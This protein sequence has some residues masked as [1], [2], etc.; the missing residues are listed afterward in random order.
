LTHLR[1][2]EGDR[3]NE[4]D[5]LDETHDVLLGEPR[6]VS[7]DGEV[8]DGIEKGAMKLI[9]ACDWNITEEKL[10]APETVNKYLKEE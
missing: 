7:Q 10:T 9:Q 2:P 3:V 4:D 6:L 8:P 5:A 1:S